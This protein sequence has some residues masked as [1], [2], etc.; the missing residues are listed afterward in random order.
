VEELTCGNCGHVTGFCDPAT[1][2]WIPDGPC[3]DEGPCRP[4]EVSATRSGCEHG[5]I[6]GDYCDASCTWV[7]GQPC[8]TTCIGPH[9]DDGLDA[10]VCIPGGPF[11]YG[12]DESIDGY[13]P[14][15][16]PLAV[17]ILSPFF[18]DKFP[19]SNGRYQEC[20]E[21]GACTV[22]TGVY[23][24]NTYGEAG[25]ED[26][27]VSGVT[28]DQAREFC[29]WDGGKVMAIGHMWEK[30]ARGELPSY[31]AYPWGDE[32]PT[33]GNDYMCHPD[34]DPAEGCEIGTHPAGASPYG[35]E[36]LAGIGGERFDGLAGHEHVSGCEVDPHV[37]PTTSTCYVEMAR[38]AETDYADCDE[39]NA[40]FRCMRPLVMSY[41]SDVL[42]D[43]TWP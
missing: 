8:D 11:L 19:V 2:E 42:C 32:A 24:E 14:R 12:T 15:E 10:E 27:P 23:P 3:E 18:I 17:V 9:D 37:S 6:S 31:I 22:P 5:E 20:V 30:A 34:C 33:C 36:D 35:V 39:F 21:D 40:R 25:Y 43:I 26:F 16:H 38:V 29:E 41:S 13:H 28:Q 4:G 7:T 1:C